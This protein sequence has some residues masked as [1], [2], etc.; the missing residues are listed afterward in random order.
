MTM[1]R[2]DFWLKAGLLMGGSGLGL[3]GCI[4]ILPET[5]P[6]TLYRFSYDRQTL[7]KEV[8]LAISSLVPAK[9]LKGLIL[10]GLS[11]PSDSA[12]ERILTR[13]GA[14]VSY[15]GRARFS[16]PA[17]ELFREAF[18]DAVAD[19]IPNSPR[20]SLEKDEGVFEV[21]IDVR[22][23]EVRYG[24]P[25]PEAV[26]EFDLTVSQLKDRSN[27]RTTRIVRNEILPRNRVGHIVSAYSRL[28]SLAMADMVLFCQS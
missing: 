25:K 28:V 9:S 18:I 13:E 24:G 20:T 26:L 19:L 22:R 16:A 10:K 7:D 15:V 27:I 8:L 12:S 2:R 17:K 5:P 23:F 4:T 21:L 6:V 1:K 3:A 11:F 14:V